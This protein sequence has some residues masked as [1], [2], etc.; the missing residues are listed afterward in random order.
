MEARDSKTTLNN[1][2]VLSSTGKRLVEIERSFLSTRTRE[3]DDDAGHAT[4]E[5]LRMLDVHYDIRAQPGRVRRSPG[6]P[7]EIRGCRREH[8]SHWE[9]ETP[10][11]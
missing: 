5:S 9:D 2:T 6:G 11:L 4:A 7:G 10:R 3:H 8:G 1:R